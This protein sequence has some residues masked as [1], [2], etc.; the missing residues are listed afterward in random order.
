MA[1]DV[2]AV[3]I[4]AGP[5]GLVAANVLADAGW[6]V[7]L[8]EAAPTPGGAVRTE[9]LT[10]PGFHHDVFSA[11]YPL[12]VASPAL[13][14]LDLEAW[15]LRWL[16][17]P[18]DLAH[19]TPDGR[20]VTLVHGDV[21]AT[22]ASLEEYAPGDGAAWRTLVERWQELDP[23]V[24][25]SLLGPFPPVQ[26]TARLVTRLGP[27]DALRLARLGTLTVRRL[28]E[29]E[30]A[31]AGGGLLLA[32]C[33][34]HADLLPESAIGG[35]FGWLMACLGQ[36]VGFP[37]PEGGAARLVDALTRRFTA[38]GGTLLTASP[39]TRIEMD[40]DGRARAAVTAGGDRFTARRAV[41]ADVDAPTLFHELVGDD[42]LPADFVDDLD[43]FQWDAATVK[44]DWAIK[45]EVPWKHKACRR[46]ATV[47][48]ADSMDDLTRVGASLAIGEIPERPFLLVG[49]QSKADPSRAP[50]GHETVWAY[51]HVPRSTV[52]DAQ[53]LAAFVAGIEAQLEAHAPGF[54]ATVIGRHVLAPTAMEER[55]GNLSLGAINAGTAQLHQQ[56]VF[57]PVPGWGRPETPV[58][59]L[60]LGGAS[61]HPGGGVHGAAGNNAA[62]AALLHHRVG[63]VL[64]RLGRSRSGSGSGQTA[65]TGGQPR[66]NGAANA[67]GD[68]GNHAKNR[69]GNPDRAGAARPLGGPGR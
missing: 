35:F 63:R 45:G 37:V 13:R 67:V 66:G 34:L 16:W 68:A 8:L 21:D 29:E 11:F 60:Y 25:R 64:P 5:N 4:G 38:R 51:T 47:H 48:L 3:V 41:I 39:V 10:L 12:G 9:E 61:A 52:F 50:A 69:A 14:A 26:A 54:C 2:D 23:W 27:R 33:A 46:A 24:T 31:G 58:P 19:P 40:G 30:F 65:V 53:S 59:G 55:N 32:G 28:A 49:Q 15:G 18:I 22:V 43:R 20:C 7:L 44:V 1:A 62:R 36:T 42:N 6:E 57:R 17:A 56:L